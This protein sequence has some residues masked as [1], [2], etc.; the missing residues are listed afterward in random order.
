MLN[1]ELCSLDWLTRF[2]GVVD[3]DVH[4]ESPTRW[5]VEL[6]TAGEADTLISVLKL[7]DCGC[8]YERPSPTVVIIEP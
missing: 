7:T 5:R 4:A 8:V 6:K 1:R 3:V 2:P